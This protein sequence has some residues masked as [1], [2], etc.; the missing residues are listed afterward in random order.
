MIPLHDFAVGTDDGGA[1]VMGDG[2]A[3]G[4]YGER[5]EIGEARQVGGTG[6]GE[7]PMIEERGLAGVGDGKSVVAQNFGRVVFGI[8]ADA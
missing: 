8:E 4:F 7:F 2:A 3:F 6:S 5:K 1:Q